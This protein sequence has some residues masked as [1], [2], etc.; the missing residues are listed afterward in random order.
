MHVGASKWEAGLSDL[1]IFRKQLSI[2]RKHITMLLKTKHAWCAHFGWKWYS[3]KQI[4]LCWTALYLSMH[5][6]FITVLLHR[7]LGFSFRVLKNC[8]TL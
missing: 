8:P 6:S 2:A 3:L 1:F 4:A 7:M 5:L